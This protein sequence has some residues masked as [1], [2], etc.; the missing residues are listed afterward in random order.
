MQILKQLNNEQGYNN[1]YSTILNNRVKGIDTETRRAFIHVY[2]V[3]EEVIRDIETNVVCR[4]M[5]CYVNDVMLELHRQ[6][7]EPKNIYA[8]DDIKADRVVESTE[9]AKVIPINNALE[10]KVYEKNNIKLSD[11]VTLMDLKDVQEYWNTTQVNAVIPSR[12]INANKNVPIGTLAIFSMMSG[13]EG[14]YTLD[15]SG[16]GA[17]IVNVKRL[18]KLFDYTTNLRKLKPSTI[19]THIEKLKDLNSNEFTIATLKNK[20]GNLETY[21]KLDYSNNYVLI[22]LRIMHYMIEHYEDKLI[23]AYIIFMWTC[24]DGWSQLTQEQLAVHMGMNASSR[25]HVK[26]YID[27][28]VDD[29]FIQHKKHYKSVKEFD[30]KTQT[31]KTKTMPYYTYNV[32]NINNL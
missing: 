31:I 2:E 30:A 15:F 11:N 27:K 13:K 1:A 25:R 14:I 10:F 19:N 9:V 22:D 3:S 8:N 17:R 6:G 23:Q 18:D 28:L 26:K 20:Q 32:V 21:Y 7:Y 29:G 5:S 16:K 4:T 12:E 24:R